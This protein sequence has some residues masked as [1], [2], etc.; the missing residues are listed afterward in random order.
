MRAAVLRG[1]TVEV[2]E[3]EDPVPGTGQIL[4]RSLAC[5]ICASDLHFMDHPEGDADDDSGMSHYD[6]EVDIVMGHEFCAEVVGY[7][8]GTRRSWSPGTRV[9]SIPALLS[10][11]GVRIIGQ[12]HE[13]PGGFGEYFL[14]TEGM[15]QVV[16]TDLPNEL[17]SIAD[18]ISV[19][20]SYVKRAD[21]GPEEVPLVIGCG[22]IG[23]SAIASL[24][25]LGIGPI[26]A[27]DFVASRRDTAL[28]VGADVV[29]DPA[30]VS[31][32]ASWREV[33]Y[34]APEPVRDMMAL[35]GLPGCVVFECVGVP[36]VLD[37]IVTGCERGTRIFSA[38]GPPDGDHLHTLVAKRKGLNIQFGGGPSMTHWNEAFVEV[39]EGRLDVTPM[40]GRSVALDEVPAA[41][42][43]AR[44]ANGPARI[45]VVP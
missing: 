12:S 40:Y 38:G 39:C 21:V 6:P 14:L 41:L 20:W 3:T 44:D 8:P 37:S 33:A 35:L 34:G 31:P 11:Q 45:I 28:A 26:V 36:G 18:A 13:A 19:G 29:V 43:A 4:V 32:Y 23:L 16:P 22:A 42:D 5:G 24:R 2:R 27:A 9:S 10:E 1:G 15:T 25:R 7:G 17:V 30:D